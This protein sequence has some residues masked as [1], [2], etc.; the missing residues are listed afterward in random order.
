MPYEVDLSDHFQ[1]VDSVLAISFQIAIHNQRKQ[2]KPAGEDLP[3]SK[4][5]GKARQ[6]LLH[7]GDGTPG[8]STVEMLEKK[9]GEL[10]ERRRRRDETVHALLL[11]CCLC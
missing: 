11:F 6:S 7:H 5:C 2:A 3:V 1:D 10:E 9:Q 4:H 8:A